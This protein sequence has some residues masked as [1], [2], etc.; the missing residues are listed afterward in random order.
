[1]LNR[2]VEGMTLSSKLCDVDL[3]LQVLCSK[4]RLQPII[5]ICPLTEL[6][7]CRKAILSMSLSFKEEIMNTGMHQCW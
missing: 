1:M 5:D 7:G 6:A 4:R 3:Q 2:D